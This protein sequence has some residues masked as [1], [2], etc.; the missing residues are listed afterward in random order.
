[1]N[2]ARLRLNF[3]ALALCSLALAG[4]AAESRPDPT[5]TK[6]KTKMLPQVGHKITAEGAL[7]VGKHGCW[8]AFDGWGMYIKT[9]TTNRS[10]LAK[11]NALNQFIH[12][13]VKAVGTLK[14]QEELKSDTPLVSGIPEH[15]FFDAAEVTVTESEAA[16]PEIP[17]AK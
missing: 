11:L 12:H 9:T 5:F 6:F 2:A 8:L 17:K 14:H 4:L 3:A 1:M 13:K 16:R 15:F 7:D 10:D